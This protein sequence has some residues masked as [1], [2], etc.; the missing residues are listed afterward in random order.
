MSKLNEKINLE[1]ILLAK[2]GCIS[3]QQ[4]I[5]YFSLEEAYPLILETMKL[6]CQ[7]ALELAAEKATFKEYVVGIKLDQIK[8]VINKQSILLVIDLI[9]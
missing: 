9:K 3:K 7:K 6:S 4:L 1:E 2:F 8:K 5:D